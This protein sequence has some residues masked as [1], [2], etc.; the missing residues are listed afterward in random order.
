MSPSKNP[1]T[2]SRSRSTLVRDPHARSLV[3]HIVELAA[4]GWHVV[5]LR[6]SRTDDPPAALWHVTIE[7]FDESATMTLVEADP[8][9]ALA[10]LVRYVQAD[11]A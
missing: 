3:R 9:V 6:P 11:A 1:K 8:G 10:E 2:P 7:R 4:I 5:G